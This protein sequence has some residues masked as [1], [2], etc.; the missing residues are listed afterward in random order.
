MVRA[1]NQSVGKVTVCKDTCR[2]SP[3]VQV[4]PPKLTSR[5]ENRTVNKR[6][7]EQN[8]PLNFPEHTSYTWTQ[9]SDNYN[10]DDDDK[11]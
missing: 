10:D 11:F 3:V 6:E 1:Q 4:Q 9:Y 5:G 8:C 2:E 7:G